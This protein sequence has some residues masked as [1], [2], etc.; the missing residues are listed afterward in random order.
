MDK[1]STVQEL[2][3]SLVLP[4]TREDIPIITMEVTITMEEVHI[5]TVAPIME[6]EWRKQQ[7]EPFQPSN[8]R[9]EGSK[10]RDVLQ[11]PEDRTL[12]H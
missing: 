8:T 2:T 5:T 3:R 12:R 7:S 10:P 6:M 1:E 11:M 4:R 9:Q